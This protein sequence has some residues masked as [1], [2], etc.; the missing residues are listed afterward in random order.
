MLVTAS[1]AS[2]AAGVAAIASVPPADASGPPAGGSARG[3]V[4]E[5]APSTATA[6]P[7]PEPRPLDRRA[8]TAVWAT[9]PS[10][11]TLR[12]A[13]SPS[14]PAV[15]RLATTTPEGT[16]NIVL[17]RGVARD[18]RG[19][20][21]SRVEGA[22]RSGQR[23]DG[24]VLS[25]ALGPRGISRSHLIVDRAASR[26][27]LVRSGRT[28]FRAPV[29]TGAPGTPTPAGRFYV[30]NKL[31]RYASPAY[32]PVAFGISARSALSD[33]P[34]GG[35]IGIHGTDRPDLV[36]GRPSHG[37]IRMRNGDILRLARLLPVGTPVV[38]L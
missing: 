28:I 37:C 24:W 2:I 19:R 1:V 31:S 5:V 11:T 4:P 20:P 34:G 13:P 9:V 30:R 7:I 23:R 14:A 21:W 25:A 12:A 33:W 35:F 6:I 16:T 29:G 38:I 3:T 22:G 8:V 15:G 32:G 10:A 17:I 27:T 18:P 36:P 26:L